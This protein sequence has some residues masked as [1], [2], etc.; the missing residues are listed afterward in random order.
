[1]NDMVI[2]NTIIKNIENM[3]STNIPDKL[4]QYLLQLYFEKLYETHELVEKGVHG[5]SSWM[6]F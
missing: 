4:K 3:R 5:E 6:N 2:C 1:M